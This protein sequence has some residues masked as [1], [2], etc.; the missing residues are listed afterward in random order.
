MKGPLVLGRRLNG[1]LSMTLATHVPLARPGWTLLVLTRRTV[2][3]MFQGMFSLV[4]FV[5][6]LFPGLILLM[7]LPSGA[8]APTVNI[9]LSTAGHAWLPPHTHTQIS[10]IAAAGLE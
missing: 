9:S 10:M 2:A 4:L 1:F 5:L 8:A 6:A 7:M 3:F